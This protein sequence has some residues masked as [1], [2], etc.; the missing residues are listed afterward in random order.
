MVT[1]TKT[2]SSQSHPP[3]TP[4]G[5]RS[6]SW[7]IDNVFA[8]LTFLSTLPV[9]IWGEFIL[10]RLELP[11]VYFGI[12]DW[13]IEELLNPLAVAATSVFSALVL[14]A[15]ITMIWAPHRFGF[16]KA[17]SITTEGI[18]AQTDRVSLAIPWERISKIRVFSRGTEISGVRVSFSWF[19]NA[20]LHWPSSTDAA[21]KTL[22]A[23]VPR[24]VRI[25]RKTA[26]L[27]AKYL[28]ERSI[29]LML[30]PVFVLGYLYALS[31]YVF[32]PAFFDLLLLP[33]V[34][35]GLWILWRRRHE[36]YPNS[37]HGGNGARRDHVDLL[38]ALFYG[39]AVIAF[40]VFTISLHPIFGWLPSVVL[41]AVAW[42]HR[43]RV[44]WN[45]LSERIDTWPP[46]V[47]I[48]LLVAAALLTFPI[49]LFA[50]LLAVLNVS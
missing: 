13:R 23:Q 49:L 47:Q 30:T 32:M 35:A 24:S 42:T 1:E 11:V 15:T 41:L 39:F 37:I 18:V 31:N 19:K 7:P 38:R 34:L 6:S 16:Y 29:C 4:F 40:A 50:L 28:W 5:L 43:P 21:E 25:V 44:N 8:A 20:T 27:P 17:F 46:I 36:P 9:F 12:F 33:F 22:Q 45:S 2:P 26:W 48:F 3:H 14:Y 10:R